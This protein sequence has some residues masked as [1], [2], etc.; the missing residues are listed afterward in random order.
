MT[1]AVSATTALRRTCSRASCLRA[2]RTT[3]MV[4]ASSLRC[5]AHTSRVDAADSR[6]S[7]FAS[8]C[9]GLAVW[10]MRSGV[11]RQA[12][13]AAHSA[14]R[15]ARLCTVHR[16]GHAIGGLA[17]V[18]LGRVLADELADVLVAARE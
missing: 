11:G 9:M 8:S 16:D 2:A 4:C 12:A 6:K 15:R 17:E 18:A 14:S 5:C 7:Y 13:S 3:A 1:E 10:S